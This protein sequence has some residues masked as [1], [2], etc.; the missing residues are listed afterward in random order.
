MSDE[1]AKKRSGCLSLV[2]WVVGACFAWIVGAWA[3]ERWSGTICV[4]DLTYISREQI[5][6]IG[7][8]RYLASKRAPIGFAYDIRYDW[9]EARS[10]V[11]ARPGCCYIK[12]ELAL[13]HPITYFDALLQPFN[14]VV[15]AAANE[16]D[17]HDSSFFNEYGAGEFF[18][19]CTLSSVLRRHP[20][21]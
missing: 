15:I 18:K 5:L 16:K 14:R 2:G 20:W 10:Y 4:K 21:K 19:A 1:P 6:L 8:D 17:A 3:M 11:Q 13:R 12:R 9:D 7:V